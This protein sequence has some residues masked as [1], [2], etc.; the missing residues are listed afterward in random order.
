MN[1]ADRQA[2]L[3]TPLIILIGAAIA[4]AGSQGGAMVGSLPLFALCGL[5]S[6]GINWLV[7]IHAYV[8]YA[9]VFVGFLSCYVFDGSSTPVLFVFICFMPFAP[10]GIS[11]F[12]NHFACLLQ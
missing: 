2:L 10:I 6:F 9:Y 4:W 1:A 3:A 12:I 11:P 7:F 5:L 8:F